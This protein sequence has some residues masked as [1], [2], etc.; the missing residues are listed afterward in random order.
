MP[1]KPLT[2]ISAKLAFIISAI[3]I[4]IMGITM[5]G[6]G[7]VPHL[8]LILAICVL[9]AIGMYKGLSFDD[10]QAQMASGV[11]RGIG[12]IYLFFFIGLMVAALM[13][14]GAIPPLKYVGLSA[15]SHLSTTISPP[16]I[17]D[18]QYPGFALGPEILTDR[19]AYF[20][21]GWHFIRGNK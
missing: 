10:L 4:G 17:F 1:P 8:S 18:L 2:L 11:M 7:W 14:S 3:V 16:F 13:K 20:W 21:G 19:P 12:A 15:E 5:I 9:L 6:F